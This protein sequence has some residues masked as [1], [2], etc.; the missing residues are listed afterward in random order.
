MVLYVYSGV[1][2][3]VFLHKYNM[4]DM[5]AKI[6]LPAVHG[7]RTYMCMCVTTLCISLQ[8]LY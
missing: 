1:E 7:E 4:Q 6:Q 2:E 8:Y 5:E 3:Y